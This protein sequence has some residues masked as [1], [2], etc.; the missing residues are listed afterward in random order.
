M[1]SR[2]VANKKSHLRTK[3]IMSINKKSNR[4]IAETCSR[5]A[6]QLLLKNKVETRERSGIYSWVCYLKRRHLF[7]IPSWNAT[8]CNACLVVNLICK[9]STS[10]RNVCVVIFKINITRVCV[11]AV[12]MYIQGN[13]ESISL[14]PSFLSLLSITLCKLMQINKAS[15]V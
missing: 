15:A 2:S 7:S 6:S 9:Q 10:K 4:F 14:L 11:Y 1:T 12:C 3:P 13:G 8:V 5:S